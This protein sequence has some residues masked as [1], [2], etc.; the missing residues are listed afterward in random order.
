MKTKVEFTNRSKPPLY[1][2]DYTY[3]FQTPITMFG[4]H[5]PKYDAVIWSNL[6]HRLENWSNSEP[7]NNAV[8]GQLWYDNKNQQLMLNIGKDMTEPDWRYVTKNSINTNVLLPLTGGTLYNDLLITDDITED[9]HVVTAGYAKDVNSIVMTGSNNNYQ[10]NVTQHDGFI[11]FNGCIVQTDFT[12]NVC[13]VST[14]YVMTNSDYVVMLSISSNL[15]S[16]AQLNYNFSYHVA[17]KTIKN[18]KV[19]TDQAIPVNCEINFTL[20]GHIQP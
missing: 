9:N 20:V 2:S 5:I 15:N 12:N 6:L 18:F 13:V 11:T 8:E 7:P 14:P 17:E 10:Y 1:L 16:T 19:V 3:N 4:R